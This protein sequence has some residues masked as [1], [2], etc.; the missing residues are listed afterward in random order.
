M[1]VNHGLLILLAVAAERAD[2]FVVNQVGCES[3]SCANTCR[4]YCSSA[5]SEADVATCVSHLQLAHCQV[6]LDVTERYDLSPLH[7]EVCI[8]KDAWYFT[9]PE[10]VSFH[11]VSSVELALLFPQDIGSTINSN[12]LTLNIYAVDYA[13]TT[14]Q[15]PTTGEGSTESV[16]ANE[17]KPGT[18]MLDT[19][20]PALADTTTTTSI[21]STAT[22]NLDFCSIVQGLSGF[23]LVL[24]D[25]RRADVY[26]NRVFTIGSNFNGNIEQGRLFYVIKPVPALEPCEEKTRFQVQISGIRQVPM[27]F[28]LPILPQ[29]SAIF[30]LLLTQSL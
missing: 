4:R 13:S 3:S 15:S 17:T 22:S 10:W 29:V 11:N 16:T 28:V 25:R 7:N 20:Q 26:R 2:L 12:T 24:V 19:Q 1:L 9:L 27:D 8:T 5:Q 23:P 18:P 6:R 21:P 14:T 30:L